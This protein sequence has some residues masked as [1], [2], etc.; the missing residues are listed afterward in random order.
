MRRPPWGDGDGRDSV[1]TFA[2]SE[3]EGNLSFREQER[4][5]Y[6]GHAA[7]EYMYNALRFFRS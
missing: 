5:S 2:D 1:F 6:N 4:Y 7:N 3:Q